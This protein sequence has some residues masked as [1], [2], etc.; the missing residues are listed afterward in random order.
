MHLYSDKSLFPVLPDFS[1]NCACFSSSSKSSSFG[2][3]LGVAPD[4]MFSSEVNAFVQEH[5]LHIT[6]LRNKESAHVGG[7]QKSN[8]S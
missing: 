2:A 1:H 5:T 8:Q 3:S 7:S 6:V 4:G